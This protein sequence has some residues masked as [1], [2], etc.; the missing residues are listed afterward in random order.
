MMNNFILC[1]KRKEIISES[2]HMLVE[3]GPGSGKTT[4][5]LLKAE[6]TIA[7]SLLKQNQRILF[8]SFARATVSRVHEQSKSI[9]STSAKNSLEFNTYHGFCWKMIQ[10]F[11]YLISSYRNLKLITPPNLAAK[12]AGVTEVAERRLRSESLIQQGWI[13]FDFFAEKVVEIFAKSDKIV[14]LVTT[15][16]PFIYLDEFQDTDI[17]E[18]E[19]VKLLGKYSEILALADLEQRIYD[20]RGASTTR[21]PEFILEFSPHKFDLGKENNRSSD[22]DIVQYGND[23]LN[24][25][26]K[27]KIYKN[28]Q[29]IKY[30][31]YQGGLSKIPLKTSIFKSIKRLN[32]KF[33]TREWSIAVLVKSKNDTLIV[34]SYLTNE[35]IGHEVIIDPN[36]PS[37]AASI[38]AKLLEPITDSTKTFN[39]VL[40]KIIAHI[41]GRKGDKASQADID[42]ASALEKFIENGKLVGKKRQL[43]KTEINSII[44]R[45]QKMKLEGIPEK[46]WIMVRQLFENSESPAIKAI[47]EDARFIK[48]LHKGALLSEKLSLAWRNHGSYQMAASHVDDALTQ[49]HFSMSTRQW[50]GIYIMNIHKSKGKE[51]DEVII[52]EELYKPIVFPNSIDQGKLLLRVAITRARSFVTFLTPASQPCLLI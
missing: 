43:I 31:F 8:L 35:K 49:E 37:L 52:W 50:K 18:W 13:S 41:K 48:L 5:A 28:V 45:R 12:M 10:T 42:L 47:F 22:T 44:E 16:Y 27:T 2:G 25:S 26:N 15:K 20:F 34:S 36:G 24:G 39:N 33:Q 1:D 32:H 51:F 40:E 11:G 21:I 23:L 6:S 17:Y 14:Q 7:N 38:I 4:L 19:L 46:D 3:G 9:I 29:I 30:P